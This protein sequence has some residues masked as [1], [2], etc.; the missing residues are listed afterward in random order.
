[1]IA[2]NPPW[3]V[4]FGSAFGTAGPLAG[5]MVILIVYLSPVWNKQRRGW[6]DKTSSTVVVK[7][8]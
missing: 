5:L 7:A 4:L 3:F 6:H 1:M 8:I 2:L